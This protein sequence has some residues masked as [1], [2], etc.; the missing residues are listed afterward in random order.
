MWRGR[1]ALSAG[2]TSQSLS[3]VG[4]N[5]MSFLFC[6]ATRWLEPPSTSLFYA[7]EATE[8]EEKQFH[9]RRGRLAGNVCVIYV[10]IL[11]MSK[12]D[13]YRPPGYLHVDASG[14][15]TGAETCNRCGIL[16]RFK[17]NPS[18]YVKR[19]IVKQHKLVVVGGSLDWHCSS[20]R[21]STSAAACAASS[22][23]NSSLFT[24]TQEVCRRQQ[25][26]QPWN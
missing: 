5:L 16:S 11:M 23:T 6:Q 19:I 24:N 10:L 21:L 18:Q 15:A 4:R 9:V 2:G 13:F 1:A 3:A 8:P 26:S 25:L 22:F 12:I 7:R 17:R 14:V 20:L